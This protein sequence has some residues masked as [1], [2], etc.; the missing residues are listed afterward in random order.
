MRG[1]GQLVWQNRRA[2]GTRR[3]DSDSRMTKIINVEHKSPQ[4]TQLLP[5]P[6]AHTLGW[7]LKNIVFHSER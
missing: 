6:S 4:R 2:A 3:Q 5:L 7:P 1:G